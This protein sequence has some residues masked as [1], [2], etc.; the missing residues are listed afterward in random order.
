[1]ILRAMETA[2]RA[3][4]RASEANEWA[5]VLTAL[6][7]PHRIEMDGDE[8]IV[9][10]P[11]EAVRRG[12][13]AL[14]AHDEEEAR[15]EPEQAPTEAASARTAWITGLAAGALLFGF[16]FVTGPPAA[17]SSWAARGAAASGSMLNGE[18]WRAVTALTLHVD[19]VHVLGNAIA[20]A[21]L[22]PPIIRRLGPGIGLTLVL[23]AGATANLLGA[24]VQGPQHVAV[25]ASTATFGA[26]G[27]LAAL[28]QRSPSPAGR[29][30][31]RRWIVPVAS[32]LLLAML[33]TGPGTDVI[34][35]ALG[36]LAGV[37][38][39]L[40]ATL[41]RRPVT[42]RIQWALTAGVALAI[43]GCWYTALASPPV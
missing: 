39:G 10:V 13:A 1:M 27:M 7:I 9:L 43:L 32:V 26:L 22:L 28:R 29:G 20:T 8:W 17:S 3:T 30:R 14:R 31:G 33:G 6:H 18:P 25:G 23:L 24:W 38:L 41:V 42:A 37:A 11:D 15:R 36:L 21:L 40:V 4:R 16:F 35:H 5:L 2:I 12:R 34:A 19:L